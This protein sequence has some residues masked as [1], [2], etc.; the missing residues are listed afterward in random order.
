MSKYV[1]DNLGE[2]PG[3]HRHGRVMP[4]LEQLLARLEYNGYF[5]TES[6]L[7]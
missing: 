4:L 5:E 1:M 2:L 7:S 3:I 6:L